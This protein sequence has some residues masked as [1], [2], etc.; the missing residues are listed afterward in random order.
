MD[1]QH[2]RGTENHDKITSETGGTSHCKSNS[3]N[4]EA[5]NRTRSIRT[6]EHLTG[7]EVDRLIDA[8]KANRWGHRIDGALSTILG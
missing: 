6:R 2:R 3:H 4:A 1:S 7:A 5:E 8:A